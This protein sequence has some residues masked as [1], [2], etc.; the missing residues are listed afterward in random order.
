MRRILPLLPVMSVVLLGALFWKGLQMDPQALPSVM[1]NKPAPSFD[2]PPVLADVPG[3]KSADLQG[4]VTLVN[5]FAS[6]CVPCRQEHEVVG[7]LA[8]QKGLVVVGIN[9]KDKP[10]AAKA[11]L[12]NLGHHYAALGADLD[13]RIGIEF[14]VYGVPESYLIDQAGNIRYKQTGPITPDAIK[15]EI[16]PRVAELNK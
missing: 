3:F 13:G 2:L 5:F 15:R 14:G 1:I 11:W 9:Y 8:G 7:S 16:L 4:K 12:G 6:W 10:E